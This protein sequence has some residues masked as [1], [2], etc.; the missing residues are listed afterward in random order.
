MHCKKSDDIF[1]KNFIAELFKQFE[2]NPEILADV[3]AVYDGG[4]EQMIKDIESDNRGFLGIGVNATGEKYVD[5]I[6][7]AIKYQRD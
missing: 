5:Q 7:K 2:D 4:Y 3:C 1:L 6:E